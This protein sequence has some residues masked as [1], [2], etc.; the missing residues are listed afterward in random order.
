V[1]R[2]IIPAIG[3]F[4][5]FLSLMIGGLIAYDIERTDGEIPTICGNTPLLDLVSPKPKHN[6]LDDF[7]LFDV[8]YR[9]GIPRTQLQS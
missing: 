7:P 8:E 2:R 5:L 6:P 3:G 9:T 1:K 4:F